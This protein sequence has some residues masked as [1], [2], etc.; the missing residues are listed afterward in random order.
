M[1]VIKR[2]LV[3]GAVN[4]VGVMVRYLVDRESASVVE[5]LLVS[6]QTVQ[7]HVTPVDVLFYVSGGKGTISIGEESAVVESGDIVVS[8]ANI[9]HGLEASQGSDF[10]V[11]VIKTPNPTR[12]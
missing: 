1:E 8:P 12:K 4:P 5:L 9:P 6:G 10:N 2:A 7:K 3:A 11:L